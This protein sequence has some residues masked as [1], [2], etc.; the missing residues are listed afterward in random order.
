[1]R[2]CTIPLFVLA[3]LASPT[4][5]WDNLSTHPSIGDTAVAR[6][7]RS[8]ALDRFLRE[9]Y[10]FNDGIAKGLACRVGFQRF[11]EPDEEIDEGRFTEILGLGSVPD[12]RVQ[13]PRNDIGT[14]DP[15]LLR[16]DLRH[17]LRAGTFGEDNPNQRARHHF[18]DPELIHP[19]PAG[20]RGLD[21]DV[22]W[23]GFLDQLA[24]ELG[25]C[26]KGGDFER[27]RT[28]VTM[29]LANPLLYSDESGNFSGRGRSA[30]DRALNLPLGED[31][32][33]GE[34][35]RNLFAFPDAE[36][37]AY[38]TIAGISKEEREQ[39]MVLQLLAVGSVLHLL[40]DQTSPGHVRNDFNSEH[41][42]AGPVIT[43]SV[44]LA[45]PTK[46]EETLTK[47]QADELANGLWYLNLHTAAHPKGEIRGQLIKK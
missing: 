31:F 6:A 45:S 29:L 30:R 8:G 38:W 21:V 36:R 19:P 14:S 27:C 20:N 9:V 22:T 11:A 10:G 3:G 7:N 12:A 41:L 39:A 46:G 17:V 13:L 33:S 35:P 37:Y 28:S 40:Q 34:D 4:Y 16:V 23:L 5:A 32:P 42:K 24:F 2:A 25:A 47:A 18:H 1:M 15:D 44:P 26:F 43:L